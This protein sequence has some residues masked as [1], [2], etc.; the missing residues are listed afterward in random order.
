[1]YFRRFVINEMLEL[2]VEYTNRY[3][4]QKDGKCINTSVKEME[5]VLGIYFRIGLVEMSSVRMYWENETR[6]G[7]VADVMSRNIFQALLT[8]IH[9][10]DNEAAT[11]GEKVKLEN[12][13]FL[14]MFREQCLEVTPKQQV[15]R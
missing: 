11:D 7:P 6:Y 8:Y 2:I 5:L 13:P 1:M 3:S 15:H 9:F 12:K 14:E 4:V 10:V